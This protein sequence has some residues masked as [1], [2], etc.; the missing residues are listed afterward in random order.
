VARNVSGKKGPPE[1][2]PWIHLPPSTGRIQ[3]NLIKVLTAHIQPS[4]LMPQ[5]QP[6]KQP[7]GLKADI[8]SYASFF[9]SPGTVANRSLKPDQ[10][11]CFP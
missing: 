7:T 5:K 6:P 3:K 1:K 11:F 2:T 9:Q 4:I 8:R 10:Q